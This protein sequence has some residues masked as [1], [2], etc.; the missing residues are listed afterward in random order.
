V[1]LVALSL[2]FS[3]IIIYFSVWKGVSSS[4]KIVYVTAPLPYILLFILLIRGLTLSG[5]GSG[6]KFLFMP[7]WERLADFRVWR[8]AFIQI[9]YS[10]GCGGGALVYY[11]SCRPKN[12]K[13]YKSGIWIPL[14]NSGTSI[15]A[16]VVLFSFL[17]HISSEMG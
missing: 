17:G 14:I 3:Y 5:A 8:D 1:P 2:F 4:G 12:S 13:V 11:A 9:I 10:S 6:L 7:K 16:A 15:F